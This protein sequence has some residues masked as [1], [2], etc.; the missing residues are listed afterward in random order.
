[1]ICVW[2]NAC[3]FKSASMQVLAEEPDN[4]KALFRRGHARHVLGQTEA[5]LEDLKK[6]RAAAPSDANI[7]RELQAVKALLQEVRG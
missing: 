3:V 5:A 6:A 1:M 4:A 2:F 7:L